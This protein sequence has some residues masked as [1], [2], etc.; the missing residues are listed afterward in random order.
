GILRLIVPTLTELGS[1]ELRENELFVE[2]DK[3]GL[4]VHTA[5]GARVVSNFT[6]EMPIIYGAYDV[7]AA[8]NLI[9]IGS[10]KILLSNRIYENSGE[11][12]C[13]VAA[14][15]SGPGSFDSMSRPT[16]NPWTWVYLYLIPDE[17]MGYEGNFN[18]I[19]SES[20]SGPLS[21]YDKSWKRVM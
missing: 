19:I 9:F 6:Q 15:S 17:R 12:T 8:I 11:I 16:T 20:D 1:F 2:E 21:P 4:Y 7:S 10:G 5:E 14:G 18:C 13:S 3:G